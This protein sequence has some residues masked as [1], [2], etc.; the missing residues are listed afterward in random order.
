MQSGGHRRNFLKN[1]EKKGRL[2]FLKIRKKGKTLGPSGKSA[3]RSRKSL[4][5]VDGAEVQ[6]NSSGA[7]SRSS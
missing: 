7:V 2:H 1:K 4:T 5:T 3:P 6:R